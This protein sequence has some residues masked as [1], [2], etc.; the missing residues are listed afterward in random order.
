MHANYIIYTYMMHLH[1][2]LYS[3][4]IIFFHIGNSQCTANI[5][6]FL[7]IFSFQI[8]LKLGKF[9]LS[10]SLSLTLFIY[11]NNSKTNLQTCKVVYTKLKN[12]IFSLINVVSTLQKKL[13]NEFGNTIS[14]YIYLEVDFLL[15]SYNL[16]DVQKNLIVQTQE[17][18]ISFFL[19]KQSKKIKLKFSIQAS[20]RMNLIRFFK[21]SLFVHAP[22][23]SKKIL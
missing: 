13:S 3:S 10:I 6:Q 12:L 22:C 16:K 20:S 8:R 18:V 21:I 11:R 2:V 4:D 23:T 15:S 5:N 9:P 17:K 7:L 14:N 1:V 19:S